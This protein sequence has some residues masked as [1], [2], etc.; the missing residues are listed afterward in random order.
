MRENRVLVAVVEVVPPVPHPHRYLFVG[1][2]HKED[3]AEGGDEVLR[4]L[5]ERDLK[6]VVPVGV[7]VSL[8]RSVA[9]A[10]KLI[11]IIFTLLLLHV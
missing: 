2:V 1:E 4:E 10:Q 5:V 7:D 6:V 3:H 8:D 9:V 11:R